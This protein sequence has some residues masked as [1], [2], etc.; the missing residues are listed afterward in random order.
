MIKFMVNAKFIKPEVYKLMIVPK[1]M[2]LSLFMV[3]KEYVLENKY[4]FKS[5][6]KLSKKII[7]SNSSIVLLSF[8]YSSI[9]ISSLFYSISLALISI[10]T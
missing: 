9:F 6:L 10:H 7:V 8:N 3:E 1:L 4:L 5:S 2:I